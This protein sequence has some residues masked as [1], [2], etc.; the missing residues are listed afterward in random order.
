MG[1]TLSIPIHV[2]R[3]WTPF[4]TAPFMGCVSAPIVHSWGWQAGDPE[5]QAPLQDIW[6]QWLRNMEQELCR[7]FG[8]VGGAKSKYVGRADGFS[9]RAVPLA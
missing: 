2:R 9:R 1:P 5:L 4:P 8:I 7:Q 6:C 3:S